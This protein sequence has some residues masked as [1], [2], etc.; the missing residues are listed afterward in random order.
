MISSTIPIAEARPTFFSENAVL[1]V[2]ITNVVVPIMPFVVIYGI[3]NTEIAPFTARISCNEMIGF[4][5]GNTIYE[6]LPWVSTV[7]VSRLIKIRADRL[8]STDI[9]DDIKAYVFPYGN[10]HQAAVCK[11]R[12]VNI[13]PQYRVKTQCGKDSVERSVR[14]KTLLTFEEKSL[15][16]DRYRNAVHKIREEKYS[17]EKSLCSYL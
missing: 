11:K 17:L 14:G 5:L 9:H 13:E 12:P 1:I 7:K 8:D 10:E 6:I 15:E 3:S 4:M 2:L 16:Y